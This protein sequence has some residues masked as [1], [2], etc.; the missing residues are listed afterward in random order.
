MNKEDLI[1]VERHCVSTLMRLERSGG[2][3]TSRYHEHRTVLELINRVEGLELL[4]DWAIE[5]GFGLDSFQEEYE[6]YKH[7]ITGEMTYKEMLIQ[8]AKHVIKERGGVYER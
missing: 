2:L 5:C 4:L 3:G 8:I 6:K 7:T 1:R